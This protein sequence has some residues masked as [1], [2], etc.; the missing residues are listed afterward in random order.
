MRIDHFK[1]LGLGFLICVFVYLLLTVARLSDER[2]EWR[3]LNSEHVSY[4]QKKMRDCGCIN[5]VNY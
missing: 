5:V 4:Y 2:D 1:G 3:Q